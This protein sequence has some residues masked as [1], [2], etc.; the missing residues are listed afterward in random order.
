MSFIS[1]MREYDITN[2]TCECMSSFLSGRFQA[3]MYESYVKGF[4]QG[5]SFMREMFKD[6]DITYNLN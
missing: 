2:D 3:Q 4:P 5:Y 6:K 1:K